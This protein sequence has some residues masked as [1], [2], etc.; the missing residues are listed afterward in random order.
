MARR[1]V[2]PRAFGGSRTS[3]R[4]VP[5]RRVPAAGRSR[6]PFAIDIHTHVAVP[7][8]IAFDKAHPLS[9]DRPGMRNW[10]SPE[11]AAFHARQTAEM[12]PKL[13]IPGERLKDMDRM[14]IDVQV[15]STNLPTSVYWADGATAHQ[16]A[17]GCNDWIAEFCAA[18]S[19]RFVGIGAV[20]L[21]EPVLAVKELVRLTCNLGL[22]GVAIPSNVQGADLG[23]KRFRRFWTAAEHLGVPVFIHPRGFTHP[24]RMQRFFLWNSVGQPLEETL[25]LC[26]LIYEGVMDAFPNLKV[27]IAHGGGYLPFYAGRAD[28]AF[29]SRPESRR[30][31]KET[32][33]AYLRRFHYDSVLF[34]PDM[35][36]Y[37]VRKV[38]EGQVMLG[39]D[40]PRGEVEWDPVGFVERT[41]G[42]TRAAR[43]KVLSENAARFF[44]IPV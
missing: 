5:S 18:A 20:P 3:A 11:S 33:S 8:V 7:S 27:A 29:D 38:G 44:G 6:R 37:L 26:S 35:L 34:N 41:P 12:A 14:G 36:E 4:K 15:I 1:P 19:D 2:S 9:D 39:S 30:N 10:V 40:Y 25:A 17:R 22:K 32:P 23:E 28:R 16:V 31:I 42:L 13:T 43:R 21:Q 24:D